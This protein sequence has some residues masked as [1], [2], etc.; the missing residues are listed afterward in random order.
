M[1]DIKYFNFP[2][3]L[4]QG[5]MLDYKKVLD[6]ICDFAVYEHSLKLE[7]GTEK[8]K[9]ESSANFY[10]LTLGSVKKA[11]YNGKLLYDSIPKNSPYVGLS[12]PIFWDFYNNHKSEF[13]KICLLSFLAIKSILGEKP[14]CKITNLYWLSR[15]DGKTKSVNSEFELSNEIRKYENEYQTSKVKRAL[16]NNWGLV[17][18][19][20]Y[21]RGFYI[22]F[23]LTLKQLIFEAEK[24]RKSTKEKERKEQEKK[25]VKEVLEEL[26][27]RSV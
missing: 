25:L 1:N 26:K 12:L 17:T 21:T 23:T 3:Q 8:E 7:Y 16:S 19:S 14:F 22:S 20:R 4:M 2:V 6:N 5:F 18:Y 13:D 9:M 10:N 15:M 27:R 24:R 11:L